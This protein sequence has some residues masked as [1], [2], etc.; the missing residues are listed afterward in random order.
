[1]KRIHFDSKYIP[2]ILTGEKTTTVRKGIRRYAV[3]ERVQ[4]VASN[5][6]FATAE[7]VSVEV[8]RLSEI[9]KRDARRDGFASKEA[10]LRDLRKIYGKLHDEEFVTIIHFRILHFN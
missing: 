8:K 2:Q 3:G 7:V 4:L 6:P 5:K 10:L 9:D 1:M